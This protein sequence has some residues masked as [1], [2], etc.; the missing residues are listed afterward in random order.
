MR[1]RL[2]LVF[3]KFR[4]L[5]S[6]KAVTRYLRHAGL[7]LPVRPVAR[8]APHEVVWRPADNPQVLG[9]LK[10]PAYAGAYV[11]GRRRPN[12]SGRRP[13]SR[14]RAT[15]AVA[16]RRLG[17]LP[18]RRPPGYIGWD[19]FVANRKRL[20]DNLAR[21]AAK[22][23]GVPREGARCCK[24]SSRAAAAAGVWGC[25]TPAD[26]GHPV[27]RCTADQ[28][29]EGRPRCRGARPAGRRRGGARDAGGPRPR[30]RRPGGRGVG[31]AG[32]EAGLLERQWS[33]KRE[34]ARYEAERARRQYDAVEPENRLVAR[35]LERAWEEAL[36][37]AE[38][39][40][41]DH[42]RWR[43]EQPL[44]LTEAD[45]VRILALGEDLPRVWH[46]ATTTAA[47]RKR[48]LRLVVKEVVLD[49]GRERGRVWMRIVWQTGAATEHRLQRHVQAYDEH[50]DLER[51]ERRVREL[52]AAGGMDERIAAALNEEGF[53]SARGVPFSG[54]IVHLLRK[55]WVIATV[56]ISGSRAHR[57]GRAAATRCGA[58]RRRWG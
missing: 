30:P 18:A 41:R 53:V 39:V 20:T 57:A 36:R 32:G 15:V 16:P 11:Y 28:A 4:E 12:P 46:A 1:A 26:G 27:Y 45:R 29:R 19:E 25:T 9:I 5:G 40:E 13:G 48:L 8:P 35:A 7:A 3:A 17:D 54:Q 52:N 2:R 10:N 31:R 44:A 55:R 6:A 21:R 37:R 22:R 33:L 49:Q 43:K 14:T 50:A 58:R 23:P 34:R 24:G 51:L 42:E 38:Q 56:K 47:E